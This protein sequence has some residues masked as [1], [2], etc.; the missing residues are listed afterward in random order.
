[1][2]LAIKSLSLLALS[3]LAVS[4]QS[5]AATA[6]PL[7]YRITIENVTAANHLSPFLATVLQSGKTLFDIGKP[8]SPGIA[9]VAETGDTAP[10]SAE[11][12]RRAGVVAT[13]K[14]AGGP[15]AAAASAS[16]EIEVPADAVAQGATLNL[17]AMIGMSNDSFVALRGLLLSSV[18]GSVGLNAVNFDAGSEENTGNIGDFGSGGHPVAGA[19]GH[20]SYDRGLNPRGNAPE[21]L[22]WGPVAALVT[23]EKLN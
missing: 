8:A 3:T 14:A 9:A 20:V 5:L 7:R 16:A 17:V 6:A 18:T 10:L 1:M 22:G 2:Q 12:D 23:V 19:E 21:T 4:T 11:L 13:T 15:V